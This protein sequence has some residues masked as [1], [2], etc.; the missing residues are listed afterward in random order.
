M[1]KVQ[2]ERI[3]VDTSSLSAVLERGWLTSLVSKTTGERLVQPF[4]PAAES[5][6]QLVYRGGETVRLDAQGA[7]QVRARG[8]NDHA[9]EVRFHSWDADGV[10]TIREDEETGDL[11]LQPGAFSN[12]P[13]VFACRWLIK[14]IKAGIDLVAPLWQGVKLVLDDPILGNSRH[15]WPKQWEAGLAIL[16]GRNGGLWVHCRDDQFRYKA[17]KFGAC[18]DPRALA[19]DVEAYG[20]VD[21]NLSAGGLPWRVNTFAGDW[22][23]PATVYRDWLWRAYGL[24]R[25]ASRRPD[26]LRELTLAVS[27]CPGDVELLDAIARKVEPQ[28]VLLH[29]PHWRTD[30]YDQNYPTYTASDAAKG[31]IAKAQAMGF[32]VAPHFNALEIDPS[33]PVH[34]LLGDMKFRDVETSRPH[35][36][37]WEK[38]KY[39]GVPC[40][41][42]ALATNRSR[43][44]MVKI[45]P[46]LSMWRS[47]LGEAIQCAAEELAL[48]TVFTDVTLHS[49][50]LRMSRVESITSTEGIMQLIDEI[51][52]I[53]K[54]LAVGGEGLNEMTMQGLSFAQAHLYG[55]GGDADGVERTGGCPLN[56]FLF[57]DLC[58]TIGYSRLS[59]KTDAEVLRMRLHEEHRAI[60]TITVRSADEILEPNPAVRD[61]LEKAAF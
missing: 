27:W 31:F 16:Q 40:S 8:I 4:D 33:H 43:N 45:H 24:D 49:C 52:Q 6:V 22:K 42:Q 41:R 32:H 57:G 35:G 23:A 20:P 47:I 10:L 21:D 13:G 38:G 19:F 15:I 29:F 2:D 53:G 28:R 11:V 9:A 17:L 46:G 58:R 56:N 34:A 61:I 55:F 54:G 18:G 1:I 25:A 14:G 26:W 44:V 12:R 37:A 30:H 39:I 3:H 7:G 5:A 50:N 60:P 51:S 48:E 36:W 59:G